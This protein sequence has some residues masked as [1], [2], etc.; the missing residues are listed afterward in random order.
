LRMPELVQELAARYEA[1]RAHGEHAVAVTM[2]DAQLVVE[3]MTSNWDLRIAY[4]TKGPDGQP[5]TELAI[6]FFID[7]AGSWIPYA[8]CRPQRGERRYAELDLVQRKLT[9]T[10]TGN[11]RALADYCEIWAFYLRE[12]GWLEKGVVA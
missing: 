4:M 9:V 5:V 8:M 7:D 10:D 12:Q 11:Q 6:R 2:G 1:D 3:A